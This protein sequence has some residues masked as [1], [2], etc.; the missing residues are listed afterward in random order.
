MIRFSVAF[1]L[2]FLRF[3]KNVF[4]FV[5]FAIIL[6][7][8]VKCCSITFTG[9]M[10]SNEQNTHSHITFF[11]YHD[12]DKKYLFNT[13]YTLLI[14]FNISR[15]NYTNMHVN[16]SNFR[17]YCVFILSH[18][19]RFNQNEYNFG[20]GIHLSLLTNNFCARYNQSNAAFNQIRIVV[21]RM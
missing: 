2:L 19:V 18:D 17:I 14:T 13:H 15:S 6:K 3:Q 20:K 16:I 4:A 1:Q 5:L 12:Q 9:D 11:K 10:F 7:I 21:P 8:E